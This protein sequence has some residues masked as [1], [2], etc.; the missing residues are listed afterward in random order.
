MNMDLFIDKLLA[1]AKAAG[2]DTAEVYYEEEPSFSARAMDGEIRDYKVSSSCGL[3]LRGTVAGKMGYA[4][5]QA[6]DDAAVD[7]L[8][9]GVKESAALVETDEQDEIFAGEKEYPQLKQLETDMDS[10]PAEDKLALC[11]AIEKAAR[12]ADE[13]IWKVNGATVAT[14]RSAIRLKNSFG[15][16]LQWG[17]ALCYA[18]AMPIAKDGDST[19]TGMKLSCAGKFCELDAQRIGAESARD[20]LDKLHGQ[21]VPQGSYRVIMS[22]DAMSDLL[23]VF[24]GIFSAENV[25]QKMSLLGD[26]EGQTIASDVVTL[27]DDPLLEGGFASC[28]FDAE[29]SASRTKAVIDKGVLTTLL[30]SRKT[31]RKQGVET[32]GNASRGS[33]AAPVRVAPTNFFFKPGEKDLTGLMADMGEGL[34]ITEL[35][36]LHAGANPTSGDFSLLSKGYTVRNG[37]RDKTVEQITVAGNFYELLKNI[38]AIGSDLLFPG[39]SVGSPSVDVGM[40]QVSGK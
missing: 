34:V 35:G 30:H 11:L 31:A 4:A 26:K 1:A 20:A 23:R 29:G 6:F 32:T 24:C 36:G 2:I 13:R 3:S 16:D 38:R 10:V 33:Y 18:Y 40:L 12:E 7:Q 27:M 21:S 25:Q 17:G 22:N 37:L 19:A 15:L 14:S 39:S 8:I 28:P 9:E 5:T